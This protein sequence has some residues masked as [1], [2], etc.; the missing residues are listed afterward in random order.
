MTDSDRVP[1][2]EEKKRSFGQ[3]PGDAL[4]REVDGDVER[5]ASQPVFASPADVS[6]AAPASTP[7][8]SP[9]TPSKGSGEALLLSALRKSAVAS[10]GLSSNALEGGSVTRPRKPC[11]CKNSKCLKLYCDCFAAGTYC[12]GCHCTNCLNLPAYDTLRQNA[13]RTSLE[14]NPHAF[15]SKVVTL[16][17]DTSSK[18]TASRQNCAATAAAAKSADVAPEDSSEPVQEQVPGEEASSTST[19]PRTTG[20]TTQ[21]HAQHI[22]GCSCLRSLC[23]KKYCECFQNG[24]YC[25]ASCRCSNCRNFEG[26]AELSQARER[27][28]LA[29][30]GIS[31]SHQKGASGTP[32]KSSLVGV[33]ESGLLSEESVRNIGLEGILEK[34]QSLRKRTPG[35]SNAQSTGSSKSHRA[36][37]SET[38]R[39][40][41]YAQTS[42]G[43]TVESSP[44]TPTAKL[45]NSFMATDT[46]TPHRSPV[47]TPSGGNLRTGCESERS[48]HEVSND[49]PSNMEAW[50]RHSPQSHRSSEASPSPSPSSLSAP[51]SLADRASLPEQRARQRNGVAGIGR[52]SSMTRMSKRNA[53]RAVLSGQRRRL[54]S[55]HSP[56]ALCASPS[57]ASAGTVVGMASLVSPC[58]TCALTAPQE[59]AAITATTATTGM[60]LG[61]RGAPQTFMNVADVRNPAFFY[62][63]MADYPEATANN[64]RAIDLSEAMCRQ[65]PTL[66]GRPQLLSTPSTPPSRA[67]AT[68]ANIA[69]FSA[70]NAGLRNGAILRLP[71]GKRADANDIAG[72]QNVPGIA[73]TSRAYGTASWEEQIAADALQH[74][75]NQSS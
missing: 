69:S 44:R 1:V 7:S 36:K 50:H 74:L 4:S 52:A 11:N 49:S 12:N 13:I 54:D 3:E 45:R 34:V 18:D 46:G 56:G 71:A 8:T 9:Q 28:V 65:Y 16:E 72:E 32:T 67:A 73:R 62:P 58:K 60:K 48:E 23:L 42:N 24:V 30:L 22:K 19:Q 35:E 15:R 37:R 2:E 70:V 5:R 29:E 14:R 20:T 63:P 6:R 25:S 51:A 43:S 39:R 31:F 68:A 41:S 27:L 40:T 61:V 66:R 21:R 47:A 57:Y 33:V 53:S 17:Y 55:G 26:S 75:K 10:P 59:Y 64:P 38:S